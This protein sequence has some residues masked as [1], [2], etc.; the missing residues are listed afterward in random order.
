MALSNDLISQFAKVTQNKKQTN[1]ESTA[2]GK[3][4]KKGDVEYVQLDGSDLLTPISSTTIVEDGDRVIVTVK[5]HT[6]IVTGDLTTP[7]ASNK[8]VIE[9]GNKI[10]EFEIIIADKVTTKQLEAEI[11]RIDKLRSDD[12]EATNAKF[13]TINGKVAEIDTI[14]S[15]VVEVNK[16]ITAHEGE[17][18]TIRA[19]IADFK[20]V[21]ANNINAIEGNFNTLNSDYADFKE[22]ATNNISANTG[23]ITN[24][25][26]NKLDTVTA[27]AKFANIDFSNIGEAAV[28]KLFTE[29]GI[30]KDLIMS[31]GKVTGELV[32]VTIKGD[33]IEGNTVKA[34]K[35][36][37]KGTDGIYYKLNV[38]ALGETT[39]ASDEKYQNGLDGSN[40]IAKSIT[41]ERIAVDDLVAF[42]ATIGG[43]H[44]DQHALYSGTKNSISNTNTGIFLSDDGQINIGDSNHY[45]KFFKDENN[46]YKLEIQADTIRFGATNT[47][48]EEYVDNIKISGRNLLLDSESAYPWEYNL[49][50]G[51]SEANNKTI[52][53]IN[54]GSDGW[55]AD[56]DGCLSISDFETKYGQTSVFSLE[57]KV[58]GSFTNLRYQLV[59]YQGDN[60]WIEPII[61]IPDNCEKDIW[62]RSYA[63]DVVKEISDSF[64]HSIALMVD[65]DNSTVGSTI[66]Y[67]LP[68]LELGTKPTEWT[69]APEDINQ[70]NAEIYEKINDQRT[71]ILASTS[72]LILQA[73]T[74]YVKTGDYNDFKETIQS[75]LSIM[76]DEI[77][78]KFTEISNSVDDLESS[79]ASDFEKIKKFFQF[80]DDGLTIGS[81]ESIIKLV[82]DNEQGIIF[83]KNGEPF[84]TWD[85]DNFYTGNIIVRVNERAQLGNYAFVPRSDGSLM[86]LRVN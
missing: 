83:T 78:M 70:T 37:I 39:A 5:N 82:L 32:G 36:V 4:V 55:S 9:I 30:I 85:G 33:L 14:K 53:T 20:D 49:V 16:K 25:E 47:T 73:T 75:Q 24:L 57:T 45:L 86:F 6:A 11:A 46:Q 43:F 8:D 2:Y 31:D 1:K 42:G 35:L 21:T 44:I 80:N 50:E 54:T 7:S 41:A 52:T 64:I 72:E 71:D 58:T 12:L 69:P 34:D 23:K 27:N 60:I 77:I 84:G 74:E 3:I 65:W 61:Y 38:N 13:E 22:L 48:I 10:S 17:F 51:S 66:E 18:T 26:T 59:L 29:S 76:S 40:I 62:V 28:Q 68:K 81:G 56:L 15:D 63:T 79:T 67:R 19:D